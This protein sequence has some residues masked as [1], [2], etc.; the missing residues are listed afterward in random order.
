MNGY[1]ID[2][3]GDGWCIMQGGGVVYEGGDSFSLPQLR[4]L[5]DVLNSGPEFDAMEW[6]QVDPHWQI[7]CKRRDVD[8]T[9]PWKV[10]VTQ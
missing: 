2:G 6:E 7:E 10:E 5:C 1:Y 9:P 4:V 3:D 8:T